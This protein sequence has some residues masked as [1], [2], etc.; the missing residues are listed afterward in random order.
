[1]IQK[2]KKSIDLNNPFRMSYHHLRWILAYFLYKNPSKDMI[3]IWVT[4]TNGK[5]TTTNIIARWLKELWEKVFMFSTVNYI[6]DDEEYTNNTK[7]TS[8]SPFLL[9]EL[10]Q[11]AKEKGC[12]IAI[13]ETSSH[14]IFYNRNR[15][16]DYDIAVLTNITQDHLDLHK[17]MQ[18]Y[19]QTKLKLF[20]NLITSKRIKWVKKTAIINMESEYKDLF[21]NETYDTLYT[22]GKNNQAS[23]KVENIISTID[24]TTFNVKFAGWKLNVETALRGTFN[25]YNILASIWVF[26]A[27]GH[28]PE[29]IE[30]ALKATNWVPG[31]L[32]EVKNSEWF[33]V[34]IDYAHT[35]DALEQVLSTLREIEWV[36]RIITVFWA[37]GERD[38]T[39][40]P[41]MGKIVSELSDVVILTQ[42]DDYSEK[43]ESII[44]D[45]LPG[46][47]RKQTENFWVIVDRKEAIRNALM[48]AQ[49][50][51]IILIAWKW[52][53]HVMMTNAWPVKWHDKDI[54]LELL[55]EMDDNKIL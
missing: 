8:P 16:I 3:V 22:Y 37:T 5:T 39:K 7:M 33:K 49:K 31:R 47:N 28:K 11:R 10:L 23:I 27:L 53:E 43:T 18:N 36:N 1:M 32:E 4:G 46:I 51:D 35:P 45:V 50:N 38:K 21:L 40:R 48:Q 29:A 19:V 54:T 52:D 24:A 13:I 15:W 2:L 26:L 41:E 42:D 17:T 30:K 44:N 34:F 6:I 14:S 25:I 9:Q 55:Q 20:K 12:T